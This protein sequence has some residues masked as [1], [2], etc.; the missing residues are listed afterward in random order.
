MD[1]T[2]ESIEL[3]L[4][5]VAAKERQARKRAMIYT[6]VPILLAVILLW[7][8]SKQIVEARQEV[9]RYERMVNELE[10]RLRESTQYVRHLVQLD[11][12][13]LK[14]L[15]SRYPRQANLLQEILRMRN[16]EVKW[17][18]GGSSPAEGF[19]SPSF[20]AYLLEKNDLLPIPFSER[21][22]MQ[23]L[24]PRTSNPEVGDLIFYD[25]GYT[26]FY[27]E[28]RY[29]EPFCVGMTPAGIVAL[30]IHFGPRLLGYGK[31]EYSRT[32]RRIIE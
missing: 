31:V 30:E 16:G 6:V 25:T 23:E 19:D 18:L 7:F 15:H 29:N 17:K 11:W 2:H 13:I 14:E 3:L 12:S 28:G 20:A 22:R 10:E 5:S 24:I 4:D 21:Y 26:M 32:R 9:N 27:F 8:T 1:T